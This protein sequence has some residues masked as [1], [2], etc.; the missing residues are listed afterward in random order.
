MKKLT[1]GILNGVTSEKVLLAYF[2]NLSKKYILQCLGLLFNA[3]GNHFYKKQ[4]LKKKQSEGYKSEKSKIFTKDE[5]GRFLKQADDKQFLLTK[6]ALIII[7][8]AGAC[9]LLTCTYKMLRMKLVFHIQI[10]NIK[11]I[12]GF[13]MV[14]I[15]RKYLAF[16]PQHTNHRSFFVGYRKVFCT[17]QPVGINR[18]SRWQPRK[19][20]KR[21]SRTIERNV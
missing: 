1:S 3:E 15:I 9:S 4:H 11:T 14:E 18:K 8:I 20:S 6:I 7:G 10:S 13:D 19:P 2:N 21:R 5:I 12:Q 16:R 17:I